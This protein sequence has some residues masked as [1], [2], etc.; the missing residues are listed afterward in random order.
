MSESTQVG[1]QG[2]TLIKMDFI[3]QL[4]AGVRAQD[5]HGKRTDEQM[6]APYIVDREERKKIPIIGDPKPI[7]IQRV[8]TFYSTMALVIEMKTDIMCSSVMEMSHEGFGRVVILAGRLVVVNKQLRDIHR[9]GFDSF[10]KMNE[11]AEKLI[12]GGIELIHKFKE[13]AEY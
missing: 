1:M 13:V 12:Q 6:L 4:I 5:L 8:Q 9:F 7:V 3:K 10:E 11:E 2:H